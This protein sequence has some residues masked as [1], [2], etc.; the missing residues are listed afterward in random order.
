MKPNPTLSKILAHNITFSCHFH[1]QLPSKP[2]INNPK[3]PS[4]YPIYSFQNLFINIPQRLPSSLTSF[5]FPYSL[6]LTITSSI[7]IYLSISLSSSSHTHTYIYIPSSLCLLLHLSLSSTL[8]TLL[9]HHLL[10]QWTG[11]LGSLEPTL[12]P[13]LSM[14]MVSPLHATNYS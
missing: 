5:P 13:P 9:L 14:T 1:L 6:Q 10:L 11:S 8:L 3:P 7:Y 2:P 4:H 12:N